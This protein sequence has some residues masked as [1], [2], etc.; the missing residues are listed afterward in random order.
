MRFSHPSIPSLLL[1]RSPVV[2]SA[3]LSCLDV[4]RG[5]P[6]AVRKAK[7]PK[8]R[9]SFRA[10]PRG[11]QTPPRLLLL[12]KSLHRKSLVLGHVALS[13]GLGKPHPPPLCLQV[14]LPQKYLKEPNAKG[15]RSKSPPRPQGQVRSL[16][17]TL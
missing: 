12:W 1:L 11:K 13:S 15:R 4:R 7:R 17:K 2:L 14:V 16:K 3:Q 9:P 5:S 10:V 6:A 8:V